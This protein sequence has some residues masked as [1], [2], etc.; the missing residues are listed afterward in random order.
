MSR[1]D[2]AD[3]DTEMVRGESNAQLYPTLH[4]R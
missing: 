1:E 4:T 3:N 2:A